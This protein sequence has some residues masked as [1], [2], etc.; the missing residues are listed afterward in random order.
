MGYFF[1]H[2]GVNKRDALPSSCPLGRVRFRVDAS[3]PRLQRLHLN[4]CKGDNT[5][6]KVVAVAERN[7]KLLLSVYRQAREEVCSSRLVELLAVL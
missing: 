4:Y 3:S 2:L 5:T 1:P 6:E 7:V